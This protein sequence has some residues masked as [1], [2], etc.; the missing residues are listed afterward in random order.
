MSAVTDYASLQAAI[1]SWYNRDD[2]ATFIDYFIQMAE[3][4][5]YRD[6]FSL[7]QGKGVS[8][9]ESTLSGTIASGTVAVPADYLGLKYA[10]VVVS[11]NNIFMERKNGEFIYSTYPDR[12]AS[13][14][15]GYIAKE[16]S[17]FIFGPYPDSTYTVGGVYWAKATG[18][19]STNTTTW[20]TSDIP[21]I[22][23]SCSNY[24]AAVQTEDANAIN[25]WQGIYNEQMG[26]FIAMAKAEAFSGSSPSMKLG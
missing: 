10:Y 13:G 24:F 19:S 7:N 2:L 11:G 20:M 6:I 1:N 22:L 23:T 17:T 9:I 15:P 21:D 5:I 8:N 26:D 12:T 3:N 18:L 25:L 16:G 4:K 14:V